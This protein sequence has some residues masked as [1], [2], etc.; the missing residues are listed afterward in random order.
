MKIRV[1]LAD[2]HAVVREGLRE[3]LNRQPDIDVVGEAENGRIALAGVEKL[4][5]D[6]AVLDVTMPELGG[7][8]AAELMRE[9]W[10]QVKV[11][12]LSAVSDVETVHR[13]LRAGA[14]G[15]LSKFSAINEVADA[16]RRVA[17]GQRFLSRSIAEDVVD[18]YSREV[19]AKSPLESLSSR[20]TQVLRLLAEGRSAAQI[21]EE[22]SVS[23]RTVETYRARLM[24]KL[25]LKDFREI[26]LFAVRHGIIR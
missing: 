13:A 24:E 15:Y 12:M 8:E 6:V 21:G 11:V 25:K 5:P 1:Y 26:V 23:P 16:V 17:T 22:L 18:S 20:E 19:N 2:D 3:L 14:D 9:R 4:K 10:P 7:I